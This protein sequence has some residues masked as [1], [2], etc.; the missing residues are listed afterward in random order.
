MKQS[1][2]LHAYVCAARRRKGPEVCPSDWVLPLRDMEEMFLNTIEHEVLSQP[3][4]DRMLDA[5]FAVNPDAER[6]ALLD[7]RRRLTVEIAN[8]T[9]AI[10]SGGDIPALAAALADR[11]RRLKALD[12]ALIKPVVMRDRDV[13]RTALELRKGEW[14]NLLRGPHVQQGRLIL[15]HLLDLPIRVMN[16]PTPKWVAQTRPGGM[17]V[18]LVQSLASPRGP[19]SLYSVQSLASPSR[20]VETGADHDM[21]S[22]GGAAESGTNRHM[23]SPRRTGET[24]ANLDMASP[25]RTAKTGRLWGIFRRA[26]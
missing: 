1:R 7:D 13:L 23:A 4:I 2:H 21:A 22:P 26:A 3:F 20:T 12:A 16:E 5:V 14:R 6:E 11:D 25:T 18:G 10:A 17:L 24:D 15:Q 19:E 8:L 9:T